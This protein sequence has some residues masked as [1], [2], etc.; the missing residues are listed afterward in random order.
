MRLPVDRALRQIVLAALEDLAS[1]ELEGRWSDAAVVFET[2]VAELRT[3]SMANP[4]P[5]LGHGRRERLLR[6]EQG[7]TR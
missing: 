6:C 1:A 7:G 5:R 2:V 4:P 3:R